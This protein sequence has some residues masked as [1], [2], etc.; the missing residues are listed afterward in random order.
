MRGAKSDQRIVILAVI[1][2]AIC[3]GVG[4]FLLGAVGLAS[5]GFARSMGVV[6]AALVAVA[7]AAV[8]WALHRRS[9]SQRGHR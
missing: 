5:L 6:V 9:P 7:L 8:G 3:C 2:A 1:A 4:P